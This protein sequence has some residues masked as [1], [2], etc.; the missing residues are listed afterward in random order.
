[1]GQY[2]I[3]ANLDKEQYIHPHG[4]GDGLKLMEFGSSAGGAMTALAILM[5]ASNGRGGGD[6][7]G[8]SPLTGSWAGDRIAII[9]DYVESGDVPGFTDQNFGVFDDDDEPLVQMNAYEYI[10]EAWENLSEKLIPVLAA[11]GITFYRTEWG[12]ISRAYPYTETGREVIAEAKKRGDII[13]E[14]S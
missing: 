4:L 8:E 5:A 11:D 7:R 1:M 10:Q 2:H 9:G 3:I 12:S 6:Y 14:A 13:A